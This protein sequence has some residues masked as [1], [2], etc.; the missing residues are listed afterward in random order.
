MNSLKTVTNKA[1]SVAVR[2]MLNSRFLK[3]IGKLTNLDVDP[4]N[5]TINAD[6]ELI[7]EGEPLNLKAEYTITEAGTNGFCLTLTSFESSRQ[8][9][10]KAVHRLIVKPGLA[11]PVSEAVAKY[12]I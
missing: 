1:A 6:I 2:S 11:V 5:H 12:L 8:W 9:L 3:G 7:S 10:N 4:A